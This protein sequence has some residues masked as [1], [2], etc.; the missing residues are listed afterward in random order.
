GVSAV[1]SLTLD[2]DR[3]NRKLT[4]EYEAE[5]DYGLVTSREVLGYE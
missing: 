2:Y 3:E 4:V 1:N 5:T